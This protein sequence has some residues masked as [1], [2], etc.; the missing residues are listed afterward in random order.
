MLH[1]LN[2]PQKRIQ[3]IIFAWY[4]E[5]TLDPFLGYTQSSRTFQIVRAHRVIRRRL[6][7]MAELK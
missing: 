6:R 7:L 2:N 3:L 4:F 5:E 1:E